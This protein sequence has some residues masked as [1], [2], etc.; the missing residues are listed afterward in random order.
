MAYFAPPFELFGY[1]IF[2]NGHILF[3]SVKISVLIS[4]TYCF[5][6]MFTLC[7]GLLSEVGKNSEDVRSKYN[8]G[9]LMPVIQ[10]PPL[11]C[12]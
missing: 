11:S 7:H 5:L 9:P 4:I 2:I 1:T 10:V 6:V 12:G 3:C 8:F